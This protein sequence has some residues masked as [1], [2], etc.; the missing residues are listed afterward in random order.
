[1][2][3]GTE[4]NQR[5]TFVSIIGGRFA[6]RAEEMT[7]GSVKRFSEK[8][9]K[10]LW[11]IL[12][13]DFTG[14]IIDLRIDNSQFG[15]QLTIVM[16]DVGDKY[17][18]QIP[19]ESRY[20]TSF[21]NKIENVDLSKEV[22]MQ[23]YDF[24]SKTEINKKTGNAKKIVGLNLYQHG[25]K[26][27]NY[28]SKENQRD[29]PQLAEKYTDAQLKIFFIEQTEFFKEMIGKLRNKTLT[30][31]EV[32]NDMEEVPAVDNDAPATETFDSDLPF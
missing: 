17:H 24:E 26:I 3:W 6:V 11:E 28:Y 10:D 25:D 15:E 9:Q 31:D 32:K 30:E 4:D 20:F 8:L 29:K 1:M 13:P 12:Y 2:G 5:K 21:C 7:K 22:K 27:P 14:R 16:D 23:P 18:F 19:V